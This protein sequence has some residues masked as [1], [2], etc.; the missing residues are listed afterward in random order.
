MRWLSVALVGLAVSAVCLSPNPLGNNPDA[1]ADESYFLTSSLQAIQKH[2]LPGWEFSASGAY[3]GG[4]QVY[5]DTVALVPA[6]G[7]VVATH[8]WSYAATQEWVALHTG[9][10]LHVLRLVNGGLV[11]ALVVGLCA[12]AARRAI[13]RLLALR[14]AL[15]ALLVFSNTLFIG[16]VH[17]AKMWVL[18]ALAVALVSA[19]FIAEE[20]YQERGGR[21]VS[22]RLYT[23]VVMWSGFLIALQA[24]VGAATIALV[25]LYGLWL[26]HI[27]WRDVR[28]YLRRYWGWF[29]VVLAGQISFA[30]RAVFVN[31]A[32][33][34]FSNI[35]MKTQSGAIDWA[36]RL[37][38][39]LKYALLG[40]P[41]ATLAV[42]AG[43]CGV[44]WLWH[45]GAL[46][47]R[48]R[49]VASI[50]ALH[51]VVTYAFFHIVV[52]FSLA[53]RY[54]IMLTLAC[55]LSATLLTGILGRRALW[56]GAV[57]AGAVAAVVGA[58][59]V[60]LYWHQSSYQELLGTIMSRYN[61]PTE[62]F[63][64][65]QSALRLTLPTNAASLQ[66]LDT[67][68]ASMSRFEFLRAHPEAAARG[69]ERF[70]TATAYDAAEERDL[71]ARLG[72]V[73]KDVWVIST[74]CRAQCSAAETS[75][76]TCFEITP[77]D[78]GLTSQEPLMLPDFMRS[79][80]LG[81]SFVVRRAR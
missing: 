17:T 78:C 64:V 70:L 79:A 50:A 15:F 21:F 43:A 77:Q 45:R 18:Y 66:F 42:V 27:T 28:E 14:L 29:V 41:V 7:V 48:Q 68:R 35:S 22:A 69:A 12:Y 1:V 16:L 19:L 56:G 51:V 9:D 65:D 11:V 74:D 34:S 61:A 67:K 47:A 49:V 32:D 55:A 23:G 5:L 71:V 38:L 10:L 31:W 58:H 52:G 26:G 3:Y 76:G 33:G 8:H 13:D 39:P 40:A 81:E 80:Q 57:V 24:Y 20:Y 59:A 75:A 73:A 4:P 60:L 36:P 2:T 62:A 30:Y 53:P 37:Y 63:V 46:S 25:G 6:L 54:G 72:A 44:A